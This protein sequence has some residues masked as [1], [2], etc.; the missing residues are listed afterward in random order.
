MNFWTIAAAAYVWTVI[1][2]VTLTYREQ[3]RRGEESPVYTLIGYVCCSVWPVVAAV[4]LVFYAPLL[5]D[6]E[7]SE[8]DD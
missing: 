3:K 4:M 6:S 2:A 7:V 5:S 1:A 8:R